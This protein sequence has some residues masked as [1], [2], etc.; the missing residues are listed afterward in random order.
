MAAARHGM[1]ADAIV[2]VFVGRGCYDGDV[3]G[4][5]GGVDDDECSVA[6][7][8]CVVLVAQISILIGWRYVVGDMNVIAVYYH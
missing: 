8:A 7:V 4:I 1:A 6:L 2:M 5:V 3:V